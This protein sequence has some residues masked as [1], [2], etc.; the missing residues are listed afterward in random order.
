MDIGRQLASS[1]DI[2]TKVSLVLRKRSEL[3]QRHF[4]EAL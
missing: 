1:H 4:N 2:S 3:A